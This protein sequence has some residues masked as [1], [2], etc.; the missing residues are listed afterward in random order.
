MLTSV[1]SLRLNKGSSSVW[2]TF[3]RNTAMWRSFSTLKGG[4]TNSSPY[5][6]HPSFDRVRDFQVKEFGLEGSIYNHKKS[7]AQV[8]SLSLSLY[9]SIYL[10][11]RSL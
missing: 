9:L 2:R 6:D 4:A 10:L 11:S 8:S 7:G 3:G 5:V 1:S